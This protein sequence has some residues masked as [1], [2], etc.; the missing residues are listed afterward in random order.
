MTNGERLKGILKAIKPR[1]EDE[2]FLITKMQDDEDFFVSTMAV[3][4]QILSQHTSMFME[5]CRQV[6]TYYKVNLIRE[7]FRSG[8]E[9]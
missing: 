5:I 1:N 4:T 9:E 3:V 8:E 6:G 7:L 2:K